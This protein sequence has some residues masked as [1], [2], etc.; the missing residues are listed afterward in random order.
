MRDVNTKERGWG[1]IHHN[2]CS[3]LLDHVI[4]TSAEAHN[5][6]YYLFSFGKGNTVCSF[7]MHSFRFYALFVL[8]L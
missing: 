5:V 4:L 6:C 3:S 8:N 1:G 2:A 7:A